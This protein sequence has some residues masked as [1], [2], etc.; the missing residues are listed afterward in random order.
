MG[1]RR[2]KLESGPAGGYDALSAF[3]DGSEATSTQHHHE[4]ESREANSLLLRPDKDVT[5]ASMGRIKHLG[6]QSIAS[7]TSSTL[8]PRCHLINAHDDH[9]HT[10][11]HPIPRALHKHTHHARL[12]LP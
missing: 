4:H 5:F 7:R 6:L 9:N 1:V 10:T 11:N 8:W 2:I 12:H 3:P